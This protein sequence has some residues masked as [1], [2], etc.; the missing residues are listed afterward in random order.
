MFPFPQPLN[1]ED[2]ETTKA[3]LGPMEKFALVIIILKKI[4]LKKMKRLLL[5]GIEVTFS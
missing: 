1:E 5:K 4:K 2:M 3:F